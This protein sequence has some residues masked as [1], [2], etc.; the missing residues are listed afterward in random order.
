MTQAAATE[1]I[2]EEAY[3]QIA[4]ASWNRVRSVSE[5]R[6]FINSHH[7]AVIDVDL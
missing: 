3:D 6:A 7:D 4:I 1:Q 2:F 5:L